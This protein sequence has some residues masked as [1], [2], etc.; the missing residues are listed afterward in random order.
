M[1]RNKTSALKPATVISSIVVCAA[2][3]LAGIGYVW[4]KSQ[5]WGLSRDIKSLEV[6]LDELRRDS[7][8]LQRQ[9]S[10]MCSPSNLNSRVRE[11]N[12]GL[13]APLPSQ[14]IRLPSEEAFVRQK[15]ER[16][17]YALTDRD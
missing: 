16:Q 3:C 2:V 15:T 7:D 12:L 4:A 13:S 10:A 5:V 9:Y 17:F 6:R 1:R 11:L 14:I 8:G